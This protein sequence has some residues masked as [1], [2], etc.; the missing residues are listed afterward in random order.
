MDGYRITFSELRE[1]E[2]VRAV[3]IICRSN[4]FVVYWYRRYAPNI[5]EMK[6][7]RLILRILA[8]CLGRTWESGRVYPLLKRDPLLINEFISEE[9]RVL[10][11]TRMKE[12]L[13]DLAWDLNWYGVWVNSKVFADIEGW[14]KVFKGVPQSHFLGLPEMIRDLIVIW[15]M[16]CNCPVQFLKIKKKGIFWL[17]VD[18]WFLKLKSSSR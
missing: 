15:L 11:D 17:K 9:W 8:L 1:S 7:D 16:T 14:F 18:C 4:C 2:R 5:A 10:Q 6:E 12:L 13:V 3:Q